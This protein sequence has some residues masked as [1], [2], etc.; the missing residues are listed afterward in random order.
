MNDIVVTSGASIAVTV[1]TGGIGT[2]GKGGDSC[3]I[4]C[5]AL[6]AQGGGNGQLTAGVGCP[7]NCNYADSRIGGAGGNCGATPTGVTFTSTGCSA[8][9]DGG[10]QSWEPTSGGNGNDLAG[11]GGGAGGYIGGGCIGVTLL[12]LVVCALI[13][14]IVVLVLEP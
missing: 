1:G 12:Y 13:V 4:N 6:R 9:G 8:G 7:S 14:V 2:N 3:F 11:G 10:Y 5:N